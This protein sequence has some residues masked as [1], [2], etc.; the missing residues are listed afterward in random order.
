MGPEKFDARVY[1]QV[2]ADSLGDLRELDEDGKEKAKEFLHLAKQTPLYTE[3]QR[4]HREKSDTSEADNIIDSTKKQGSSSPI[5][6][7]S[8]EK[9]KEERIITELL[10]LIA[11]HPDFM[12]GVSAKGQLGSPYLNDRDGSGLGQ[13]GYIFNPKTQLFQRLRPGDERKLPNPI[14]YNDRDLET[15]KQPFFRVYDQILNNGDDIVHYEGWINVPYV[16]GNGLTIDARGP[17]TFSGGL[18]VRIGNDAINAISED[19]RQTLM[20]GDTPESRVILW[21]FLV[22]A[23]EK[24]TPGW[25]NLVRQEWQKQPGNKN[26][27]IADFFNK[28]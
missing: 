27:D 14:V 28:A 13:N 12:L 8:A 4:V 19:L 3:A 22:A 5:E 17:H 23:F 10:H 1:R 6:L 18:F 2:I 15:E 21:K 26:R 16:P 9:E 7:V 25:W 20:K 11:S 24:Y